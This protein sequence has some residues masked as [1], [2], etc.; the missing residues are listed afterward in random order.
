MDFCNYK[1]WILFITAGI[2]VLILLTTS[3]EIHTL[4][5]M[6]TQSGETA[7]CFWGV[8]LTLNGPFG[9]DVARQ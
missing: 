7:A 8:F 2:E 3:A 5:E 1:V 4:L 9:G 6:W